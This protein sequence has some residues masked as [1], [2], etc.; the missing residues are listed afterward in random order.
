MPLRHHLFAALI[1][2]TIGGTARADRS[3][4]S[5]ETDVVEAGDCELEFSF[6]RKKAQQAAPERQQAM[7]LGCGIGWQT[8]LAATGERARGDGGRADGFTFEAKTTLLEG[9]NGFGWSLVYGFERARNRTAA[10][11]TQ[12]LFMSANVTFEP[13]P[14]W[15]L[16]ARIGTARDLSARRDRSPWALGVE[17]AVTP[18]FEVRAALEGADRGRPEWRIGMRCQPWPEDLS[19]SLEYGAGSGA[20]RERSIGVAVSVEF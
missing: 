17:H 3:R 15:L 16:E 18:R 20:A 19:L 1:V 7:Q 11:R 4:L 5:A 6:G 10:W 2:V 9:R 8:E 12:Q 14:A 13:A